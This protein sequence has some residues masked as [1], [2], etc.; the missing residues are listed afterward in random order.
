MF[1]NNSCDNQL[2]T[3]IVL[4]LWYLL[5]SLKDIGNEN[6]EVERPL[7][8]IEVHNIMDICTVQLTELV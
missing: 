5:T 2:Y 7:T 3:E 8:P 4:T 6:P 1:W